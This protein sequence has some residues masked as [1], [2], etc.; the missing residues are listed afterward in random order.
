MS[1]FSHCYVKYLTEQC[2]NDIIMLVDV[3][4]RA[5]WEASAAGV[6][7]VVV[8]VVLRFF[9]SCRAVV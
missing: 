3:S 8:M 7:I 1:F 6:V 5:S 4:G 2:H 9:W